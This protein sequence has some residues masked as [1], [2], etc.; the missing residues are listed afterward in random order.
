MKGKYAVCSE[1]FLYEYQKSTG[2][3]ATQI[4]KN[5]RDFSQKINFLSP[6]PNPFSNSA[7]FSF[8]IPREDK[9]SLKIYDASGRLCKT[10]VN[11]KLDMGSYY[12]DWDGKEYA[13]GIY[14]SVLKVG[15][16]RLTRKTVKIK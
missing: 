10:L 14:F 3:K 13:D 11:K 4:S 2:E 5:G 12:F 15:E 9:V 6:R 7:R 16:K 8:I 1:I